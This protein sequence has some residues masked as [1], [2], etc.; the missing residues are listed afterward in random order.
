MNGYGIMM[1]FEWLQVLYTSCESNFVKVLHNKI[2]NEIG[3]I[4]ITAYFIGFLGF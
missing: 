4:V 3:K 1:F 2:G